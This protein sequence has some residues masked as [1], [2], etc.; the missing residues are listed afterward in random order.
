MTPGPFITHP[1]FRFLDTLEATF[2]EV[3]LVFLHMAGA[4]FRVESEERVGP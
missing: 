2:T 4:D 3:Q 1:A